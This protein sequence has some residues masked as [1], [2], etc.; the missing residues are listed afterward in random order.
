MFEG[1][2]CG[3]GLFCPGE[4][5]R[6]WMMAV[7]LVRVL[8]ESE[9]QAGSSRFVD[10]VDSE[11]WM[12][13]VER[14]ADLG[15]THGCATEPARFCPEDPVTRAQ[16]A[17]FLARAFGLEAP[18]GSP[19]V[20]FSDVGEGVHTDSIYAL[21]ASGI[22][23]GCAS[24][25]EAR[26]CPGRPTT[27]AQMASFLNR[28]RIVSA[29]GSGVSVAEFGDVEGVHAPAVAALDTL[30]VFEGT[31]CGEGLFCPGEPVR[32]WTMAVWLVRVLEESEPQA[33]SSRFAD[34]DVA[35][36][37]MPHV[38]RLADLG[39]THGCATEPARFCPE[40]PVTRA[41]MASFLSR[42][43]GLEAPEGSPEVVFSDVGEGVHTDSI[44]A[45]AA[46]GITVGCAVE[47]EARFC[48][49]RFT[50]RAQM[51]SFLKRAYS[52]YVG[53]CPSEP[54]PE[55]EPGGGGGGGGGVGGGLLRPRPVVTTT[56]ARALVRAPETV[57]V[58]PG[59]GTLAVTW[60]PPEG[61]TAA[62]V[63]FYRVQWRGPGQAYSD[64]E[65]WDTA[66][67]PRYLIE[68]LTNGAAY[69][70]RVAAGVAGYGFGQ[71]GEAAMPGVPSRVPGVPE[72]VTVVPGDEKLTV[73]W[74]APG[75]SGGSPVTAYRVEH[76][77]GGPAVEV[78]GLSHVIDGLTNGARYRVQ[79]AAVN[80]VGQGDWA[81]IEGTP[82]GPP[83][84]PRFVKAERAD[85]SAV[86]E[87]E[88][89]DDD[90]GSVVTG[91]KVQWRTD[92]QTF[93]QSS[94]QAT[95]TPRAD[96]DLRREIK[97]L[98][99]GMEY[100]V[101]VLAVNARGDGEGSM[102]V[103]F[104]PATSP[105][106]PRSVVA[107]RGDG[108]VTVTWEE[109]TDTGG[110]PVTGYRVQW[111]AESE[112]YHSSR[113]ATV[114][115]G[116][117]DDLRHEMT[118]LTNGTE[119]FVRVLAVN[120]VDDGEASDGEPF[121]PA[122]TPGAPQGVVAERGDRSMLV[123]WAA[124]DDGGSP[125]TAYRVQWRPGDSNFADSDPKATVRDDAQ[126]RRIPRLDNG[127]EY[128]VQVMAIN[129][130]DDGPWSSPAS[131]TPAS[132]AGPPTSV[133]AVRGDRS[134]TVT[135]A[136]PTDDGG[137][138]VTGYKVQWRAESELY[139]SSRQA[140]VTPGAGEDL[141]HE[142]TGLANGTEYFVRVL[143]V[144]AVDDGEPSGGEP[145]TPAT[146][147]GAPQGVVAERGDRSMLVTWAA[148]DSGG[149]AVTAY[150]VQWR[151][152]D[153]NFA[154]SDPQARVRGDEQSRRITGLANGTEY[155][156][157]VM[158]INDVGDGGWSSPASATPASV[159]GPPRS[160][161]AVRGDGS[162]TVTWKEPTDNGGSPV[163]GYRVQWRAESEL[164]HDSDRLVEVD[165]AI[166]SHEITGLANG[167]EHFVRV[168]ATNDVGDGE[169]LQRPFTPATTPGAP[170]DFTLET[171][172]RSLGASWT[173][174]DDGGSAVTAYR[175]QWRPGDSNF[176][177]SDPQ[178]RVGG[179][180]RSRPITGLDNGTEYF[181]RVRARNAVDD[182]PW[183]TMSALAA[184][185]PS[186]PVS[187]ATQPDDGSLTVTW[188]E[189]ESLGGAAVTGYQV[190]WR[191]GGQTFNETDLQV[192]VS[193]TSHEITGLDNGT[194]YWV[195]VWATNVSGGGPAVTVNDVP[196]TLPGIPGTPVVHSSPGTLT[197]S[198]DEPDSDGG[199][200]ITGYRVQWKGPG[201]QYN[202]TDRLATVEDPRHQITGLTYG[203]EYTLSIAAVNAA[204]VGPP[205]EVST[206]LT[207]PPGMP[208]SPS[209]VVS[210]TSLYVS[211]TAPE[212]AGDTP[213]TEYRVLWKGPGETFDGTN[214]SFRRVSARVGDLFA[215]VGPLTNATTYDI[216]IVA[217]NDAGPGAAAEVSG[218]PAAI[219]GPP[220]A[221]D[222]FSVDDGLLVDWAAPWD[223][224]SPITG[225]R[226]QWKGS[227]QEYNDSDRLAT[228]GA[229]S[230][231][232]EI[233]GLT[234]GSEYTVRVRAVSANGSS[235]VA[236]TACPQ[237]DPRFCYFAE[238][239][240][241]PESDA[242]G[243]PLSADAQV[244]PS[245]DF[246]SV[247]VTWAAPANTQD[248]EREPALYRVQW[249][250]PWDNKY[251]EPVD[252][253]DLNR[254]S[255]D[256]QI[257]YYECFGSNPLFRITAVNSSGVVSPPAEAD[258]NPP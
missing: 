126:S 146:T 125:V 68:G 216:Q 3:E 28:A 217:V 48:P 225:Y 230:L 131:A 229:T 23:V 144:N 84:A 147:P 256:L 221:V 60:S 180:K 237:D 214:C 178:A 220:R 24:E 124:A 150:R 251:S 17:S 197:V 39:I 140:T 94:R 189:P 184:A 1:T 2:A 156:V 155:F 218:T 111:R 8:E 162:V 151:P 182:G 99:N 190:Q 78:A 67:E 97:S 233:T 204:G 174:P 129:D 119:Y 57:T 175:V 169:A 31:A 222:A 236:Q 13:Y 135:W 123:T 58:V 41:Q 100:F 153:S 73:R 122:T 55:P 46:S 20:V 79:V 45:L 177:D 115:P 103:P 170:G 211:W 141:R 49:D 85:R 127:T 143:A 40:D 208:R 5:V 254:L 257:P 173:K 33:G 76:D 166:G 161:A 160:V 252:I 27:R 71:W 163:T 72:T 158:A 238:A 188:E 195:R 164:Y 38:E 95:V 196:R 224:G 101:R 89:P 53:P 25:P 157:Q 16:M 86:V 132:V 255:Y 30:G 104:T 77:G 47:R 249:R 69:T 248:P 176:E 250:L 112:L 210:S 108:S 22:T 102:E 206:V 82:V 185:A 152:D 83:D 64:S 232:H 51:A 186:V 113:Q 14:L 138:P 245:F 253:T 205:I 59:D 137:S 7:W 114:T 90:G 207:S 244:H 34:V 142:F 179:D 226:V 9:P 128:F 209:V 98:T 198:W 19:E 65:R 219:P 149:S 93:N 80:P 107:V 148:A 105:G 202:E 6:R 32:R 37:W 187:V 171:R 235:R 134:V 21:A 192:T 26:F 243:P 246:C 203:V 11:W 228:V 56:T 106:P 116:A 52:A 12:P 213:I 145:F 88:A 183:V 258:A 240:G 92:R 130:V 4:P 74:Q 167:T 117:G 223:G 200:M 50:T 120:A 193:G 96:D 231:S 121:T 81:E 118:G 241:T 168:Y 91:Y 29:M 247:T 18:E 234:N 35:A 227:G 43:F 199:S 165:P 212:A 194:E 44:Y 36:W 109:P 133:A 136:A 181:V 154:G 87:W 191:T 42:A 110:S 62:N 63:G 10:V 201:E 75:D 61:L 15:I 66:E 54:E 172:D 159:A 239:T 70:V 242:P 139:H 215:V